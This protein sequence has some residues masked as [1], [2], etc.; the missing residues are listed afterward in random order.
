MPYIWSSKGERRSRIAVDVGA[1]LVLALQSLQGMHQ[2]GLLEFFS[3]IGAEIKD[4][5]AFT[6]DGHAFSDINHMNY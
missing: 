3:T 1:I 2:C 4:N 6:V 5:R